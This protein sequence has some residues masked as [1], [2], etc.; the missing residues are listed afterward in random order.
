MTLSDIGSYSSIIGL[1]A[2]LATLAYAFFI[3]K[4]IAKL[5]KQVLFS[6]RV[7]PILK[8][9]KARNSK[10]E[11]L[12]GKD[13]KFREN[14]IKEVLILC[15]VSLD[16][17]KSK[18]PF[19]SQVPLKNLIKKINSVTN[20][21]FVYSKKGTSFQLFRKSQL[22]EDDLWNLYRDILYQIKITNELVEDRKIMRD[23]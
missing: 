5:R 9:L 4:K 15:K 16:S 17:L 14:E 18:M 20:A 2:T 19:N 7:L 23:E 13:Y 10:F 3:D 21:E 12:I 11:K 22:D 1:I 8:E 6:T